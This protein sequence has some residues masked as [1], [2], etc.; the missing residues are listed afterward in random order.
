MADQI[1]ALAQQFDSSLELKYN[2]FYIGLARNGRAFN[3]VTVRPKKQFIRIQIKLPY[4]VEMNEK[5]EN[6]GLDVMDYDTR[7]GEFRIRLKPGE[8][9]KNKDILLV[10]MQEAFDRMNG[11]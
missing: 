7:N 9:T 2:K 11:N 5:L 8:I 4:T 1:L 6:T 10:I 3:F